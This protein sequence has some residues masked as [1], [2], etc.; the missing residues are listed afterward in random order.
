MKYKKVLRIS[1][2]IEKE[3]KSGNKPRQVLRNAAKTLKYRCSSVK[4]IPAES[5]QKSY[6]MTFV[7]IA[8]ESLLL[9]LISYFTTESKP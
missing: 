5:H 1:Y 9:I 6:K 4:K 3:L 8:L 7:D 2:T